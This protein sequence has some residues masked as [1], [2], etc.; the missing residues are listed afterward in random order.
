MEGEDIL[1]FEKGRDTWKKIVGHLKETGYEGVMY[2]EFVQGGTV[3]QF[4]EDAK[5]LIELIG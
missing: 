2:L 4:A 3:E 1:A 5:V